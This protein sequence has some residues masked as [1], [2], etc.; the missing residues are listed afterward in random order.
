MNE[1]ETQLENQLHIRFDGRSYDMALAA[2]DIGE[3]STD[4]DI[5]NAAANHLGIPEQK[6]R[7]F[8]VDRNAQTNSI[9]LRPEAVFGCFR[10]D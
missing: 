10:R 3:N 8:A 2:L 4:N 9:T 6:L 7:A 1:N 5:R